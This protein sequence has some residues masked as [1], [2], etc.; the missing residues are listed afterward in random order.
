MEFIKNDHA[1]TGKFRVR[2]ELP[3]QDALGDDLNPGVAADPVFAP[4]SPADSLA[5]FLPEQRG[6]AAGGSPREAM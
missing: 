4:D 3:G 1:D 2:L 6:N 5:G